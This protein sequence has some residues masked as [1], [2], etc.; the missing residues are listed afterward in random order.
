MP[1]LLIPKLAPFNPSID[2]GGYKFRA[3]S[4]HRLMS[5]NEELS[6]GNKNFLDQLFFYGEPE[7]TNEAL[8]KG[9]ACEETAFNVYLPKRKKF[10][11]HLA[12]DYI[13][14]T[15]DCVLKS[16]IIDIKCPFTIESFENYDKTKARH[17][18]WQMQAYMVLTG[19]RRAVIMACWVDEPNV[20]ATKRCK[21]FV[22]KREAGVSKKIYNKVNKAREYLL[23]L[24]KE[25]A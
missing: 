21:R 12:N 24:Q 18:Y 5:C 19:L 1:T 14:G 20:V 10:D 22:I 16:T 9:I 3:S 7:F 13:Q 25:Y 2:W 23:N 8:E 17:Y 11:K 4:L 15:P 6:Q